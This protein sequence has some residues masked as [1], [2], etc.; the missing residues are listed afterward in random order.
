MADRLRV[1]I[2]AVRESARA[3]ASLRDA[4]TNVGSQLGDVRGP[5][6]DEHLSSRLEDLLDG[7]R[8]HR[9]QLCGDLDTFSKWTLTAA[10]TYVATD[11][12]LAKSLGG[13]A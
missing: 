10:D 13:G 11:D 2:D 1:D 12:A 6:G 5:V 4:M 8:I 7:W 9:E 3:V